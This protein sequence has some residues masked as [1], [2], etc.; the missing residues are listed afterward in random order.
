M[1]LEE[2]ESKSQKQ[3]LRLINCVATDKRGWAV[4]RAAA[5]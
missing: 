4:A 5:Q 3:L 1:V 2:K